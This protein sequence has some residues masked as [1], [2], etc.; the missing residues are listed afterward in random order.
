MTNAENTEHQNQP[1]VVQKEITSQVLSKIQTFMQA[2]E[3]KMPADYSPENALKGA[4]LIL[5]EL[6]D[7]G[8]K[9]ALEVC[10]KNS[11]ANALL[12]MCVEGLS[13]LKKQ[14]YFVVYGNEV[15][16]IRSYQGS[17]ALARR[18]GGVL[19]VVPNVIYSDDVFEYSI[20]TDTGYKK[21]NTHLQKIENID[22]KK[23]KGGYAVVIYAD[24]RKDLEVMTIE[25]IKQAWLQGYA[26]GNS[27]AHTNFTQEMCKKT[28]INRACKTPINSSSDFNL[29]GG[30]E[31]EEISP[32]DAM[33]TEVKAE[34]VS[35]TVNFEEIPNAIA[36]DT[37]KGVKTL[38][39]KIEEA[40]ENGTYQAKDNPNAGLEPQL[41]F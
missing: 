13:V 41:D 36:T 5:Q 31:D 22:N 20:D 7:K 29:I 18:V 9:L 28:V 34:T 40:K 6:K 19:D 24:G 1:A 11:I 12:K 3:L 8:G 15:Q 17:I 2:G 30:D 35:Q 27:G 37:K 25:E 32:I 38:A 21:I 14:G 33:R 4:M 16:W 39:D 26:K 10:T 23:I